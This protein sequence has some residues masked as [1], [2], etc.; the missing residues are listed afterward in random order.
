[1]AGK[2]S[3]KSSKA[4]SAKKKSVA[5][6]TTKKVARKVAKSSV[7]KGAIGRDDLMKFYHDM[8][9]IRR[10]E[11]KAGQLYG[12]GLIGGFCHL[13]IGQEAV[14]VGMTEAKRDDDQV[15]T[16]YRDHGHM[17]ACGMD[18]NG[19]MAELTGRADGYSRGKGGSMHMFSQDKKF[20]GGH[21]IVGA[22]VPIGTGLA[23][24]N[25]YSGTDD[26][27]IAY[28]GDGAANQG[29]IYESFN[30]A[31]VWKLP[32]VYVVE[33]NQYAMGTSI[34]RSSSETHLHK[35]G[36][37]FNIPG[38]EV[39]GMDVVAVRDAGLEALEH[40]RSGKGPIIL[41]MKTYRYRGHSMSDP[42]KYRTREE[43]NEVRD[44]HDPIDHVR[45]QVLKK[46]F[47]TEDELKAIDKEIRATVNA[48]AQFAQD[49]P[50][51]DV[52]ELYTDVLA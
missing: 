31:Q 42:A 12:M 28:Y 40:C 33:N 10:F 5:K 11:E 29:Q 16:S 50:E 15:I 20:Y 32:V 38:V 46:K 13:Y 47:A 23:F 24:A 44:H 18:P 26:V 22:Q 45:A 2:S 51:P 43:V 39:D 30:I 8:L 9:M 34:E 35:R 14:V 48:A 1:M 36:I 17:L 49:S 7:K 25:Q 19:V 41:E 3:A 27:S 4:K 52:A 37:S 21:G 6:K